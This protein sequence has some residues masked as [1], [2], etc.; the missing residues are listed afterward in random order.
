MHE[1][2]CRHETSVEI[3]RRDDGLE[4]IR[5]QGWLPLPIS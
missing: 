3:D 4:R 1:R 2:L 5:Q